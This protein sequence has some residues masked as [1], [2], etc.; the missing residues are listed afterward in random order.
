MRSLRLWRKREMGPWRPRGLYD[1]EIWEVSK[2]G[3]RGTRCCALLP[4]IHTESYN[5]NTETSRTLNF[6]SCC[7]FAFP[8]HAL[9]YS[10]QRKS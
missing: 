6:R 7:I 2:S 3:D 8:A 1:E 5:T 4:N 10:V 9:S